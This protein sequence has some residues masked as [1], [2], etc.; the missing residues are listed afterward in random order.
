V[1]LCGIVLLSLLLPTTVVAAP[2]CFWG[3]YALR[4]CTDQV[5]GHMCCR[6]EFVKEP[7]GPVAIDSA[8]SQW[9]G[10]PFDSKLHPSLLMLA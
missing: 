8:N 5:S 3:I 6:I 10:V 9:R 7:Y 4:L 2:S 1:P